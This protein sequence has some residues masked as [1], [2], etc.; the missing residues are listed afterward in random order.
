MLTGKRDELDGEHE[1]KQR[2]R[3]CVLFCR[4]GTPFTGSDAAVQA[5]SEEWVSEPFEGTAENL[6]RVDAFEQCCREVY[7]EAD[8]LRTRQHRDAMDGRADEHDYEVALML[9]VTHS[10]V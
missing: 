1:Q 7:P 5:T 6:D 2:N 4:N 3:D 8:I 10:L 9:T